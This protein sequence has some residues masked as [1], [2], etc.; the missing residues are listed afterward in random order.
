M[1]LQTRQANRASL[2]KKNTKQGLPKN[3]Q[4]IFLGVQKLQANRNILRERRRKPAAV[5]VPLRGIIKGG[6]AGLLLLA[7]WT[8]AR[9][10]TRAP[11]DTLSTVA[12]GLVAG[13]LF[14]RHIEKS[15]CVFLFFPL[16]KF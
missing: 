11:V 9:G 4:K 12:F 1:V 6:G 2:R 13:V 5:V 7:A 10:L 14:R 8:Q 16:F 3:K 15:K